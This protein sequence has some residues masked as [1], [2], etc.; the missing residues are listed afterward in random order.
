[1]NIPKTEQRRTWQGAALDSGS[2]AGQCNYLNTTHSE[3]GKINLRAPLTFDEHNHFDE[4]SLNDVVDAIATK[5]V[6]ILVPL[7]MQFG[8][9]RAGEAFSWQIYGIIVRAAK[10][11]RLARNGGPRKQR[12]LKVLRNG[13]LS[14]QTIMHIEDVVVT[15]LA[16]FMTTEHFVW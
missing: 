12:Q 15:A 11:L 4:D 5:A 2:G 6:P 7:A 10:R 9:Q 3:A 14:Q 16:P 1:M 13:S 8:F